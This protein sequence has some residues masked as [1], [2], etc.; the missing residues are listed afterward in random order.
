MLNKISNYCVITI[1]IF[2]FAVSSFSA[3]VK[4]RISWQKVSG[5]GGYLIEL[6]VPGGKI[7]LTEESVTNSILVKVA[8]G[9]YE[10]RITV[11]DRFKNAADAT[12]WSLITIKKAESPLFENIS[13]D[14]IDPGKIY[15]TVK[16]TGGSFD[17]RIVISVKKNGYEIPVRN[18]TR[19]SDEELTFDL[20]AREASSGRYSILLENPKEKKTTAEGKLVVKDV[21]PPPKTEITGI[22]PSNVR[23][24][25]GTAVVKIYGN[26][27]E[28]GSKVI[29][30]SEG[31]SI[32]AESEFVSPERIDVNVDPQVLGVGVFN[33]S[34]NGPSSENSY[35]RGFEI[36]DYP[37]WMGMGKIGVSAGYQYLYYLPT[38]KSIV[39]NSVAGA[40]VR[41][42]FPAVSLPFVPYWNGGTYFGLIVD[43]A[44]H[45]TDI[46]GGL[47]RWGGTVTIIPATLGGF[48]R[49]QYMFGSAGIGF[50][51]RVS[52][53][54]M[55][56]KLTLD[57]TAGKKSVTSVDPCAKGGI[58]LR[59]IIGDYGFVES[60]VDYLR[61]FYLDGPMQA[62]AFGGSFGVTF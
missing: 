45:Q 57:G 51:L 5:A 15:R 11:L 53:G 50:V 13:P 6:R 10:I 39:K 44:Y 2:I 46:V 3:E 7:V 41:A 29:I 20:D 56:T 58:G 18:V 60:S 33:V 54:A 8:E 12:P 48:Y 34:V 24:R 26:N 62:L 9:N 28:A 19:I 25:R 35:E 31:K 17:E 52:G 32:S 42:E 23:M 61:T 14:E 47:Y 36:T 40:V 21:P 30:S 55:Y 43:S 38:W 27:L 1:C 16:I 22:S 59:F 4:S 37:G 49:M